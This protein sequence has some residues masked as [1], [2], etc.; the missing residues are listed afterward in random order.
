MKRSHRA[1][2][3]VM[4]SL[5]LLLSTI[6]CAQSS[7][8]P[9]PAGVTKLLVDAPQTSRASTP[10]SGCSHSGCQDEAPK[11]PAPSNCC[12]TWAPP[13]P[14]VTLAVPVLVADPHGTG[15]LDGTAEAVLC[16][17]A[18]SARPAWAFP[19]GESPPAQFMLSCSLLGRAPPLA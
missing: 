8:R 1:G 7:M 11:T 6:V 17:T 14:A 2:T 15:V 18:G 10:A 19:P 4:V 3:S 9:G 13:V 5:A 16:S 12:L